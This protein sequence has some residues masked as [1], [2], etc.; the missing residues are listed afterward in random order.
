MV[1]NK[2]LFAR[3][4]KDKKT[5][6][7]EKAVLE[8]IAKE[9]AKEL[10]E[11]KNL[12]VDKLMALIGGVNSNGVFNKYKEEQ[13][14]KGVKFSAKVL[15]GVD[16]ITADPT[17]WTADKKTNELVRQL[18]H[19]YTIRYGDIS[20]AFKR[21]N[22]QVSIGDELPTGIMKMAKVYLAN[23]RKLT[24]GDK[25]AGRHGNKGI[26]SKIVRDADMPF[27]EDG[28]MKK[29]AEITWFASR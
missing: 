21:K 4:V 12:L 23:K 25:M 11:L 8:Q 29:L 16:Y 18:I 17:D 1:I 13:I 10:A 2:K 24:V 7:S 5:K 28:R 20:G 9:E 14:R 6:G 27:L 22:F 19:N 15:G 26:V 3:A